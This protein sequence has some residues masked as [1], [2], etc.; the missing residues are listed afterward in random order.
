MRYKKTNAIVAFM[1]IV[2]SGLQAQETVSAT[3]G[4]ATG[5]GGSSSYTVGQVVY[6]TNSGSNG[7]VAQGVQQPYEIST[8]IGIQINTVNL[9]LSAYPNPTTDVLQLKVIGDRVGDLSFQLLDM[10]GK[11]TKSSKLTSNITTVSMEG[12]TPAIYFLSVINNQ[13]IVRTF[14]IIKN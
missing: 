9:E 10:Q 7:S 4:N 14:R 11:L 5:S 6:T 1:L 12:L 13:E 8:L 3:G 2:A